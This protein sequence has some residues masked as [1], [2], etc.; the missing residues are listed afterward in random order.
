MQAAKRKAGRGLFGTFVFSSFEF[1]SDFDIR[2]FSDR[3][4]AGKVQP[5]ALGESMHDIERL[6][7][8]A[9]GALHQIINSA[10]D[11]QAE[12]SGAG[13]NRAQRRCSDTR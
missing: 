7:R 2:I 10:D 9:C 1:V 11:D 13:R 5:F 4:Q 3:V 6:D 8:L 12:P